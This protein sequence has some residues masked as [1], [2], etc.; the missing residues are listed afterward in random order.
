[1]N[2]KRGILQILLAASLLAAQYAAFAHGL[3]HAQQNLFAA[4][5][6]EDGGG[7]KV[8]ALL[9]DFHMVFAEVLGAVGSGASTPAMCAG[10][11]NPDDVFVWHGCVAQAAEQR[12]RGPPAIL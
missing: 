5:A 2:L 10:A 12:S 8:P 7:Q 3:V 9:C 11:D 1:M 6:Q 4:A